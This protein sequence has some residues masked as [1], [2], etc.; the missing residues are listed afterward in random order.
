MKNLKIICLLISFCLA[1][2]VNIYAQ[3]TVEPLFYGIG[4]TIEIKD[5]VCSVHS[6][7]KDS[8]AYGKLQEGDIIKKIDNVEITG[9]TSET[10]I[11]KLFP[12]SGRE[13]TISFSRN[14]KDQNVA[15]NPNVIKYLPVDIHDC[16]PGKVRMIEY[17]NSKSISIEYIGKGQLRKGD[18]FLMNYEGKTIATGRVVT[19]FGN[20][21]EIALVEPII[22]TIRLIPG[23]VNF[24]YL[25]NVPDKYDI[26]LEEA[27]A[28]A[29]RNPNSTR[30]QNYE[31]ST[32][33]KGEPVIVI[34]HIQYETVDTNHIRTIASVCNSGDGNADNLTVICCFV[35]QFDKIYASDKYY[36][37]TLSPGESKKL[38]FFS[39]IPGNIQNIG[40]GVSN[41]MMVQ[42]GNDL[43]NLRSRFILQYNG[44]SEIYK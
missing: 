13:I 42:I 39:M 32:A 16:P 38:M 26:S 3:K 34:Q 35:N 44:K 41:S 22:Q 9:I 43:V 31:N 25:C 21:G 27:R 6:L 29:V 33:K 40:T 7:F 37:G 1:A 2:T 8:P 14:G 36:I 4:I 18:T 12:R 11:K 23:K 20:R 10:L 5:N 28:K 24:L 15:L 19:L 30:K 17:K